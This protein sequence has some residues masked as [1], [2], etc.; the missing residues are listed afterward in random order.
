M[1]SAHTH[2]MTNL[3]CFSFSG[4]PLIIFKSDVEMSHEPDEVYMGT[5]HADELKIWAQ[6][7]C[8]PLVRSVKIRWYLNLLSHCR[9]KL[10]TASFTER[11]HLIMLKN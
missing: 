5:M 6:E 2:S 4:Q 1:H 9:N 3:Q 11:L 10:A 7:K 8:I